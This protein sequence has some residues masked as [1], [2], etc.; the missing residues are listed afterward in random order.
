MC[1]NAIPWLV[2][3]AVP[4]LGP[5]AY[6]ALLEHFETPENILLQSPRALCE[7]PGIGPS[8]AQSI[9]T[10][11]DWDW[12]RDQVSRAK[13]LDIQI[14]TLTDLLYPEILTQIYAP[15]P[16]LFA[17]G[18]ISLCHSPTISIVGS[19]S[20][21][22][23]GRET[24]HRLG[25][26]LARAGVTVVSGMAVGIDTH[27]HRGA[28]EHGATAAVLGSS[29]DCPYP[30]E[31]RTLFQQICERG[32]VF[33]EFPLGTSPEAHNFPRRNRIISGLSLGTVVVEAGKQ[34][35]ALITAQFALDQNRDVFAVP[36]P[37]YSGKSQG[38]NSLL[39]QGA[40]LVQT[41]QDILSEIEH[42]SALPPAMDRN[43]HQPSEQPSLSDREQRVWDA[44]ANPSDDATPVH[45]DALA[46][47]AGFS[48]GE[49]LNILLSLEIRGHVEQLPG[50]HFRQK[51]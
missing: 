18:D 24:A 16:L 45:I 14:C 2:L 49:T 43:E 5:A 13:D 9:S 19:R 6:C 4:G 32:V 7:I 46:R 44:L 23:Y 35:G 30:P 33:S 1:D 42:Q 11:R 12:A 29:L 51:K 38:T 3:Y 22:A 28:L 25:S 15:P 41:A 47:A 34:S 17:K 20:F 31:N 27:A 10:N 21:T 39:S 50:M 26:D 37:I 8:T 40:I 36:G 48:S